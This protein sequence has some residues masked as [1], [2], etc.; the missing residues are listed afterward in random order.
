[1]AYVL[2]GSRRGKVDK[3]NKQIKVGA[4][5]NQSR[6]PRHGLCSL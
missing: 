5:G 2:A 3:L 6:P 4:S 1:M